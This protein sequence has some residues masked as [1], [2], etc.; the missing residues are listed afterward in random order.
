MIIDTIRRKIQHFWY[1]KISKDRVKYATKLGVKVGKNVNI[2]PDPYI[3][4]GTEPYLVTLGDNVEITARV[5]FTTH[6]GALWVL[7]NSDKKFKDADIFKPIVIG[8]NVFIGNDSYIMPGVRIGNNV[9]VGAHSV[10][11]KNIPDN[12]IWAGVPAREISNLDIY[13]DK[14]IDKIVVTK[15]MSA[16]EKKRYLLSHIGECR[17][18]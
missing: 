17:D 15:S 9:I 18:E 3:A 1:M 10:V 4:F 6:D 7:R 16:E 5:Q 8:N 13:R 2:M 11:T 12:S 14:C